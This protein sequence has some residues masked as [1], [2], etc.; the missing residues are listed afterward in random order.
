MR[1]LNLHLEEI[2]VESFPTT[3]T[4]RV[5]RGTVRGMD[6]NTVDQDT[7]DTCDR[8]SDMDTCVSCVDTCPVTC[9]SC[10]LSCDP[11]DCP[12]SDGRC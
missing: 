12:S 10:P 7:C 6:S 8:C 4:S 5:L 2:V 3:E 9:A 11:A 1:K